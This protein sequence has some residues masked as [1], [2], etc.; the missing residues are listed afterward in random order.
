MGFPNLESALIVLRHYRI[1]E[2]FDSVFFAN[3][4]QEE[5]PD[6]EGHQ[7]DQCNAAYRVAEPLRIRFLAGR[8]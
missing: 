3:E 1:H 8:V 2:V 7:D 6:T 5:E 4:A